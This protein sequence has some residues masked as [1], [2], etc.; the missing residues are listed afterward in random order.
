LKPDKNNRL[1]SECINYELTD[2]NGHYEI[3]C[4][5]AKS[6]KHQLDI[7][8]SPP[9]PDIVCLRDEAHIDGSFIIRADKS[10]GTIGGEYNL[11]RTKNEI[12]MKLMPKKGWQPNEGRWIL[13]ILFL[14]V[15]V[16]KEWP[17]SYVWNASIKLNET[18]QP[19]MESSWERI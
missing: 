6:K 3:K 4:I 5:N 1:E 18:G 17:K 12:E 10:R 2:N 13:K 9:I 11:K 15:K 8:F 19:V 16:F 14:A 7:T